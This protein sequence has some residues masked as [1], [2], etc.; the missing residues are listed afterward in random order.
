MP[1]LIDFNIDTNPNSQLQNLSYALVL[2]EQGNAIEDADA[3]PE[4]YWAVFVK[5]EDTD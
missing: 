3:T 2:D 4:E 5:K 1:V